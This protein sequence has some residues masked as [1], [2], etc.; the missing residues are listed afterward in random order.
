M[1]GFE[2]ITQLF[3]LLIFDAVIAGVFIGICLFIKQAKC[4]SYSVLNRDFVGYFSNPTGYVF[5][6][7]FIFLGSCCA[8]LPEEFFNRNLATLDE[9]NKYFPLIMLIFIPA[10]T[11][12]VWSEERREGTDEL[13]LTMPA[14]D[15]DIVLGKY[16]AA[17]AIFSVA[18]FFSQLT[19]FLVLLQLSLGDVDVGLFITTYIGYWFMGVAMLALGMAASFLTSNLTVSFI[20]GALVNAPL[21]LMR[22]VDGMVPAESVAGTVSWWSYLLRFSDFGRGVIS[23]AS[24]SYFL[25]VAAVGVYASV[26]LIGRRHWVGGRDGKS[27]LGH[28]I[29]R[30][31]ALVAI[32]IA[33]SKFFS[34]HDWLRYDATSGKVASLSADTKRILRDL[35]TEKTVLVEAFISESMPEQYVQTK[36]DLV[37]MLR[38]FDALAGANVEIRLHDSMD[39]FTE[40]AQRAEDQYGITAQ[41]VMTQSR[42]AISQEELFLGA[43]FSCGLERVIVPFFD[44]GIPVEYE[45]VRSITTVANAGRLRIGV[46]K[47]D[48]SMFGGFDMQ[49]FRQNPKQLIIQELEKQYDVEEVDLTT[50]LNPDAYDVLMVVQPS[51]LTQPALNNLVTAISEGQATAIFEDPFPAMMRGVPGTGEERRPQGGGMFG[52]GRPPEPKGDI[53]QL[54]SAL[55]IDMVTGEAE[56]TAPT[57]ASAAVIWQDYNPYENKLNVINISPEWVFVSPEAPGV[58]D[59]AFNP[60]DGITSGL[61]QLL[62]LYPGA[63]R[64]LGSRGLDFTP[65]VMTGDESGEISTDA[66]QQFQSDPR[67]L[68]FE[69]GKGYTKKRYIVGARIRGEVRSK[70]Q[71][72]DAGSPLLAQ[73]TPALP[74]EG[75]AGE[76]EGESAD[77]S[78]GESP[79]ATDE[80]TK[81]PEIHVVYIADIDLLS[82]EF[83]AL[84]SQP[85]EQIGWEFDNVTFVL[86]VLDSLAGDE[87]LLEIR[88]RKTRHSTLKM[89]SLQLDDARAAALE[90]SS[91]FKTKFEDARSEAE[92]A[93]QAKIDEVNEEVAQLQAE[94]AT[95]PTAEI[96][97]RYIA[98]K[99]KEA[100]VMQNEQ[101]KFETQVKR[102]EQERE[103]ERKRIERDMELGIR[104]VQTR[105]KRMAVFLPPIPPLLMGLVVWY[106]RRSREKEGVQASRLR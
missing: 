57:G 15:I 43:A 29:V 105:Y 47:T 59:D 101:V 53:R 93:M 55:G 24:M 65:L 32:A 98:A 28:F 89:V 71:M 34:Y 26:I 45:L 77:V 60:E 92:A 88:K 84:R 36:V 18:L 39:T 11:M 86:N 103:L 70:F 35:E 72:S 83:M 64:D 80:E 90:K 54:W 96:R 20:L 106:Y 61:T 1:S 62:F 69:R 44:R 79:A 10:I 56:M 33:G 100:A 3:R 17:V 50:P 94:A 12:S 51:S 81:T 2:I 6:C 48:A 91:E 19:N 42:G 37:N 87:Q 22:Y 14:S 41:S 97:R 30:A 13:L 21:V 27:M 102:L 23:W 40:E 104:Q 9:L 7:V 16:L 31:F 67:L 95:N 63:V 78:E 73:A 52:G 85:D 49:S 25:L 8:F 4:A 58:G 66:V 76:T 75:D 68:Q 46:A 5:I 38:E 82:S 74:A 99:Q